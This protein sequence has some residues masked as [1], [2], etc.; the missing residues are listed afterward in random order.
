[1]VIISSVGMDPLGKDN[2]LAACHYLMFQAES[3]GI[4]SVINGFAQSNPKIISKHVK[5]P[6]MHKTFAAINMGYPALKFAR[7]VSRKKI[8]SNFIRPKN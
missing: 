8:E 5:L 1:M 2:S 6:F 3:M 7:S 4:G